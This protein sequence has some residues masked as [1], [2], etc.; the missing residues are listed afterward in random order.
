M[1]SSDISAIS[2]LIPGCNAR[3]WPTS[4][5]TRYSVKVGVIARR[6]RPR[7]RSRTSCSALAGLEIEQ[8]LPRI[9]DIGEPE[10]GQ[11]NR[12]PAA[13]EKLAAQIVFQLTDLLREGGLRHPKRL[14]GPR[15]I[16]LL[17]DRDQVADVTKQTLF[18]ISFSYRLHPNP[19]LDDANR[20]R[21]NDSETPNDSAA[22]SKP[23]LRGRLYVTGGGEQD[24]VRL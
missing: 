18:S 2:M 19:V 13:I 6:T 21:H 11:A 8:G 4:G 7:D 3:N 9:P 5:A 24:R 23:G 12:P 20:A 17:G 16:A 15:E 10:V 22:G 14:G 1:A